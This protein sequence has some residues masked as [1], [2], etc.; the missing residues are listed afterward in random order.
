VPRGFEAVGLNCM[1]INDFG[2]EVA[3]AGSLTEK[4]RLKGDESSMPGNVSTV[5]NFI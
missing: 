2:L 1:P 3:R 4:F 5:V